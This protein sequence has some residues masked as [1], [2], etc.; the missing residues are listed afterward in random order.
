MR[1]LL[2]AELKDDP[3]EKRATAHVP[4]IIE[5]IKRYCGKEYDVAYRSCNGLVF[6]LFFQTAQNPD[7]IRSTLTGEYFFRSGDALMI[8]EVGKLIGNHGLTRSA[9]W[10]LRHL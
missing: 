9:T 6:G 2:M 4:L 10:L 7:K 5:H 1:Y 3:E 8:V